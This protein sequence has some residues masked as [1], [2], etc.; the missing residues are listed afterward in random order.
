MKRLLPLLLAMSVLVGCK[1]LPDERAYDS[2]PFYDYG[3]NGYILVDGP[4]NIVSFGNFYADGGSIIRPDALPPWWT[5][6]I[7]N[8]NRTKHSKMMIMW[9]NCN[10]FACHTG[11]NFP[12]NPR[13]SYAVRKAMKEY[14][15]E[16]PVCEWDK[17]TSPVEIHHI[18]P[19]SLYPQYAAS[20]WNFISLSKKAHLYVG[21]A[22]SYQRYVP[23]IRLLC[24][25]V[26]VIERD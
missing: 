22:G 5:T 8:T 19:V 13:E 25:N 18:L 24:N 6:E 12:G 14:R 16:H 17:K 10:F 1:T 7:E 3:T 9:S 11:T 20:K 23:N 21:H 4:T 26:I 2:A 15:E